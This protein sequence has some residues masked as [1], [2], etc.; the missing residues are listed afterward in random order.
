[1]GG[2]LDLKS[3]TVNRLITA[4]LLLSIIAG[5]IFYSIKNYRNY[6]DK[7]KVYINNLIFENMRLSNNANILISEI[8]LPEKELVTVA[9]QKLQNMN[10]KD[11]KRIKEFISDR[12]TG[13]TTVGGFYFGRSDGTQ[14]INTDGK[15]QP[16]YN[17][18]VRPWY[19]QAAHARKLITTNSYVDSLTGKNCITI[20]APVYQ[21]NKLMGV[22]GLDIFIDK[23]HKIFEN[24]SP[25]DKTHYFVTDR[26]GNIVINYR[27]GI[28]SFSLTSEL[29]N[30]SKGMHINSLIKN[31]NW[32]SI[33]EDNRGNLDIEYSKN[34]KLLGYFWTSDQEEWKIIAITDAKIY[35]SEISKMR[36]SFY[37][38]T[39]FGILITLFLILIII[40]VNMYMEKIR[41]KYVLTHDVLTGLPNR[42]YL[43]FF[44]ENQIEKMK[45]ILGCSLI[46]IDIDN[47]KFINDA[48]GHETGDA[49]LKT[50]VDILRSIVP[51][52]GLLLRSGGDEFAVLLSNVTIES[53]KYFT[54]RLHSS[55][56]ANPFEIGK[57][58]IDISISIGYT[59]IDNRTNIMKF[60]THSNAALNTAKEEGKN[61]VICLLP[62]DIT[63]SIDDPGK[64][65][66]LILLIKNAI[67]ENRFVLFLQPIMD[68]DSK[69]IRHFEALIRL[70][71]KDDRLISPGIF[72][73][74][75]ERFGLISDIDRWVF[76]EVMKIIL[77][78]PKTT[79][80]MNISGLSLSNNSLL[81]FFEKSII[82]S[83]IDAS[84]LNLGLEITE[85][86]STKNFV[87]AQ[88]WM[89]KFKSLGCQ[90]A[91]DDFG[92]G[93][94]SFTYLRALPVDYIKIDGSF[95]HNI[96]KDSSHRAI[97]QTINT[98]AIS[99]GK[100][101]IAEFVENEAVLKILK[102]IGVKYGQGYHLG[103]PG[104][105]MEKL[106]FTQ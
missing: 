47:F 62:E 61:K 101:T 16:D 48:F 102:E 11:D 43:E 77:K 84:H 88:N 87:Q 97:V 33:F 90:I 78:N 99:L 95:V 39:G 19:V 50:I 66:E 53:A 24:L 27:S 65:N 8:I 40:I 15:L 70:R 59:V 85:T 52:D 74:I 67:R 29:N 105:F 31:Q 42:K 2:V 83:G 28:N 103:R 100:N 5:G 44:Y 104:P 32:Y 12:S 79:V 51:E 49:I 23:F 80:F 92:V 3:S 34:E 57:N 72:I 4:I 63:T 7:Q 22:V 58:N 106:N 41:L 56:C 68:I 73:P 76:E 96:D 30:L 54:E 35:S 13:F 10:L 6:A 46:L 1:M 81:E 71:G 86:A 60:F 26:Y 98:L 18:T 91:L 45:E 36:K 38:Y 94:T 75:A 89:N 21:N 9:V 14:F 17:P 93:Y 82:E 25:D 64:I 69:R 55:I 37:Y 20:A